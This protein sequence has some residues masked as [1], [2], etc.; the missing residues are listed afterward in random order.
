MIP[1]P[2]ARIII[3]GSTLISTALSIVTAVG[4]NILLIGENILCIQETHIDD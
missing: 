1:P 3:K 4:I 2:V